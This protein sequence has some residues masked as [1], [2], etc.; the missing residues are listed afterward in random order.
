MMEIMYIFLVGVVCV[1]C[2]KLLWNSK[3]DHIPTVGYS[4]PLLLY[5]SAW[6]FLGHAREIFL[7]GYRKYPNQVWKVPTF[8]GW[9][10]IANGSSRVED[11][12]KASEEQLN[13]SD[14]FAE[15][16]QLDYTLGPEVTWNPYHVNVVRTTLTR[17][18]LAQFDEMYHELVNAFDDALPRELS[19]DWASVPILDA[20]VE[21]E[22]RVSARLAV[23]APLCYDK[24][25]RAICSRSGVSLMKGRMLRF[26]PK[27]LKPL[28]SK[29]FVNVHDDIK[30]MSKL[31]RPLIDHRLEEES[32]Q[33]TQWPGKPNDLLMW[34]LDEAGRLGVERTPL[35]IATRM[36]FIAFAS[37]DISMIFVLALQEIAKK[38]EKYLQPLR[39]EVEVVVGE[40]G[41]SKAAVSKMYKM[42]SF[43]R[44]LQRCY[45]VVLL[46]LRRKVQNDFVFS[47]GT[48]VPAGVTICVNSYGSHHD[49]T[50]FPLPETFNG[51]RFVKDDSQ[52][53]TLMTKPTL[54]YN[55]FGYGKRACPGRFSAAY[56]L[57]TM[58][59][60]VIMTYDFKLEESTNVSGRNEFNDLVMTPD[61][62]AQMLFRRRKQAV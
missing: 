16:L 19:S 6:R 21:L 20:T 31:L 46:H 48:F 51:F 52:E 49:E 9:I 42:D 62:K 58:L 60:H 55:V 10:V 44:E 7:E 61:K 22:S 53:Q 30:T 50:L 15:F 38:P 17:N 18:I 54:E 8:E 41:W 29:L 14:H 27:F 35:D 39:D 5:I 34:M 28:A 12:S 13:T 2:Y 11:V 26:F 1:V 59:A 40:E 4:S 24:E 23:G 25:Y 56:R 32:I 33:G 36:Y 57:K 37:L 3:L 43:F 47:D 45:D